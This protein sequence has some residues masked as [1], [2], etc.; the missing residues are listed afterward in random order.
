MDPKKASQK[1]DSKTNQM[2]TFLQST[3]V[4]ISM[5]QFVFQSL[6][7]NSISRRNNT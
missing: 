5:L 3:H 2:Q 4:M 1:D 7:T 6:P